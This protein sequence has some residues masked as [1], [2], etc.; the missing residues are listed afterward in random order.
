MYTTEL[1]VK[2]ICVTSLLLLNSKLSQG[3]TETSYIKQFKTYT[4]ISNHF[5]GISLSMEE[6][7]DNICFHGLFLDINFHTKFNH[8]TIGRKNKKIIKSF[9]LD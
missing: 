1:V 5:S 7:K 6:K 4:S 3:S 8:L 9:G 2:S